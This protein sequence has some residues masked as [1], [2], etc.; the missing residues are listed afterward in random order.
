MLT[1]AMQTVVAYFR[2]LGP[3]WGV[4]PDTA[5][6][7]AALY[8]LGRPVTDRVLDEC[9]TLGEAPLAEA[10][11]DLIDWKMATRRADGLLTTSSEPWDLIFAAVEERRRRE[12]SPA[13]AALTAAV[14]MARSDSTP[15]DV[16]RRIDALAALVDDLRTLGNPLSG[17]PSGTLAR[18]VGLGGRVARLFGATRR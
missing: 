2:E 17:L 1:P 7:H 16:S 11:A 13:L 8:L 12:I 14:K 3:R 15:P 18:L 5:A 4:R 6:A 9:L 10:V